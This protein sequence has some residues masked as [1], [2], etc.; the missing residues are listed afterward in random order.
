MQ[1]PLQSTYSKK[2][3]VFASR[4]F[5]SKCP[6]PILHRSAQLFLN[7]KFKP[8]IDRGEL[9]FL[10]EKRWTLEVSD[11]C[12][13]LCIQLKN[14]CLNVSGCDGQPDLVFKGPIASFITLAL[15]EDDPDSLFFNRKLMISGDTALG[16][17]IK[18][19]IDRLP[20]DMVLD[21]PLSTLLYYLNTAFNP[22]D[23]KQLDRM[24]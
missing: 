7:Q 10:E 16:L 12:R 4:Q 3:T 1:N 6:S 19:F 20:L 22:S 15:K 24:V 13:S 18:N 11:A 8:S 17:E 5:L 14:G 23:P 9:D 2:A 21:R